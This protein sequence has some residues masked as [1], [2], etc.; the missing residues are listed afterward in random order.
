[1]QILRHNVQL[2]NGVSLMHHKSIQASKIQWKLGP[3]QHAECIAVVTVDN[4]ND[5][6]SLHNIPCHLYEFYFFQFF[7]C[8]WPQI[9]YSLLLKSKQRASFIPLP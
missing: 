7:R 8:G 9:L 5:F 4:A 2:V 6:A 1:M 3:T